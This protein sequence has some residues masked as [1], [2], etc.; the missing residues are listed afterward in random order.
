MP[1]GNVRFPYKI[2]ARPF[3]LARLWDIFHDSVDL[4][5]RTLSPLGHL[6]SLILWHPTGKLVKEVSLQDVPFASTITVS[7]STA[8]YDLA[9]TPERV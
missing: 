3:V 1:N 9:A 5:N 2:E 6:R 7:G 4:A 8:W